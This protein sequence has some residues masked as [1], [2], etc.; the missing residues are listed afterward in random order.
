MILFESARTL[1]KLLEEE[2]RN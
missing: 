1:Q 2:R